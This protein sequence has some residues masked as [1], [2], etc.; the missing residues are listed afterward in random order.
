MMSITSMSNSESLCVTT[1]DGKKNRSP[2]LR[3]FSKLDA[4]FA[5]SV[6]G[7]VMVATMKD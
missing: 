5:M 7:S 4:S 6:V 3:A 1:V 2:V